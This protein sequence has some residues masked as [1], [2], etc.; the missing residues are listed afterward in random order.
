MKDD[1]IRFDR[2]EVCRNDVC[3]KLTSHYTGFCLA[4]RRERGMK[5][6]LRRAKDPVVKRG[7]PS[8]KQN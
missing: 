6:K 5:N 2:D 8:E 7:R 3:A 1:R 4:C